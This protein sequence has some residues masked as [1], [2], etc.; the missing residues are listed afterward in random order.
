MLSV[1]LLRRSEPE[2]EV[3]EGVPWIKFVL[4][5]A[6]ALLVLAVGFSLLRE[7]VLSPSEEVPVRTQVA[8]EKEEAGRPS[9]IGETDRAATEEVRRPPSVKEGGRTE[10]GM[11]ATEI[12]SGYVLSG[13]L[14]LSIL[15]T[16]ERTIPSSGVWLTSI[17]CGNTGAYDLQG[18]AFSQER[19]VELA[20]NLENLLGEAPVHKSSLMPDAEETGAIRFTVKGMLSSS[21]LPE[22]SPLSKETIARLSRRIRDEGEML[23]L[24][25]FGPPSR[26]RVP[27][28]PAPVDRERLH[29]EGAWAD[30][31]AFLDYLKEL[32]DPFSIPHLAIVPED[33]GGRTSHL[34]LALT[35]HFHVL[36]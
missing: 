2:P 9:S 34:N 8:A 3:Q 19:V 14:C 23:G 10:R 25:F 31:R 27:G 29:A 17:H 28:T 15:E 36:E 7:R 18:I 24:R 26:K 20:R 4:M 30:V 16:L 21:D 5:G 12:E 13:V 1:N 33:K 22:P 11:G 35:L 6:G 32:T